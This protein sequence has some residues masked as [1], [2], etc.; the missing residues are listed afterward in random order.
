MSTQRIA[1]ETIV[2]KE[3]TRFLRIWPQ[4]LLPPAITTTLYFLIFGSFVG[5]RIGN[6]G[7]YTYMEYIVP[8]LIMMSV[9]T[10]A[11]ANVVSSFFSSK[12]QRNVEEMMVAP[13]PHHILLLGYVLGGVCRGLLTALIVTA[14]SLFFV[15]MPLS[16]PLLT[17]LL[18]TMAAALFSLGG[19]INAIYAKKF[20][21]TSIVP[22]FVLTPLTYLGGVFY[23]IHW[24]PELWQQLSLLN[25]VLYL[26][27]GFRYAYMGM[28]DVR[29]GISLAI[30]AVG[31][32]SLTL[33]ALRLLERGTGLRS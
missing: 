22:T 23:S 2:R 30:I 29:I 16:H 26:V 21:D 5:S 20:D 28:A 32:V 18:V 6:L 24:L 1:L 3:I 31:I 10:N 11:Y 13:I 14:I 12:F 19:F 33:F 7:N 4:T 25:P 27:N 15:R 17:L 8:G 9:I